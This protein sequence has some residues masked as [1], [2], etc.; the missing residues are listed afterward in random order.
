MWRSQAVEGGVR[1]ELV[2]GDVHLRLLLCQE[3]TLDPK[4]HRKGTCILYNITPLISLN[5][6]CR[7]SDPVTHEGEQKCV[8]AGKR[9]V[10]C[11]KVGKL[12]VRGCQGWDVP[13][14]AKAALAECTPAQREVGWKGQNTE[15]STKV[16]WKKIFSQ[17][18]WVLMV[19]KK[20]NKKN[21]WQEVKDLFP[22][23]WWLGTRARQAFYKS[24]ATLCIMSRAVSQLECIPNPHLRRPEHTPRFP[25]KSLPSK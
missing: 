4:L 1:N 22:R 16:L 12:N 17:L 25:G 8:R 3:P 5:A 2:D 19:F 23:T 20:G 14:S 7:D 10:F 13:G 24:A 6:A 21:N 11:S 9:P 18:Q 15:P